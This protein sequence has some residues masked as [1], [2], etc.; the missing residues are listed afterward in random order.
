MCVVLQAMISSSQMRFPGEVRFFLFS[1]GCFGLSFLK[2][3]ATLIVMPFEV[4]NTALAQ[5]N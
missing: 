4:A 2:V 3:F 1:M 5:S